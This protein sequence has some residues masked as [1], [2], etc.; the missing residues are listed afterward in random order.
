[1]NAP[2]TDSEKLVWSVLEAER[3]TIRFSGAIICILFSPVIV[4]WSLYSFLTFSG[5]SFYVVSCMGNLCLRQIILSLKNMKVIL[6]I[7]MRICCNPYGS[8]L[9]VKI[10]YSFFLLFTDSLMHRA[11]FGEMLYVLDPNRRPEAVKLIEGST[12]NLVPR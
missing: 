5:C 1:M 11:A 10:S 4:L 3:Q 8:N 2:V 7:K 6:G 9:I 12:N